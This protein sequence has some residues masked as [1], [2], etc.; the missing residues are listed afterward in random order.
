[1][2]DYL[3]V[4]S[5]AHRD[6]WEVCKRLGLWGTSHSG[7]AASHVQRVGS[8]D[9]LFVWAAGQSGGLIACAWITGTARPVRSTSD[10]P[11]PEP[12]RYGFTFPVEL[13]AELDD[14][15]SDEFGEGRG[16]NRTS[17]HLGLKGWQLQSGFAALDETQGHRCAD[18]FGIGDGNRST[19]RTGTSDAVAHQH[20]AP[21]SAVFLTNGSDIASTLLT[22]YR[23]RDR[24]AEGELLIVGEDD[25]RF[26][27]MA[28]LEREPFDAIRGC[29]RFATRAEL[30]DELRAQLDS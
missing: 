24:C 12:E 22:L 6:N 11:W 27:V 7:V 13:V 20:R 5:E 16:G 23:Q 1:M 28:E 29:V 2:A 8:G 3:A 10:V 14:P 30:A 9:R 18:V 4:L 25:Q 26:A 19:D 21:V 17:N 15:F